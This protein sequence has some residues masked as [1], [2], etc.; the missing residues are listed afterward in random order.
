MR[1]ESYLADAVVRKV[2]ANEYSR[3]AALL[4]SPGLAPLTAETAGKLQTLLQPRP[5]PALEH[6]ER[7]TET[8]E[9][10]FSRK[11][12]K[13]ALRSSPKGSGAAVGGGRFEHWRVVLASP[14]AL[15]ISTKCCF[16]W[17]QA[18][19]QRALQRCSRFP[20]SRR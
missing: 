7:A 12:T 10:S 13:Q 4:A 16:L 5:T 9:T 1:D 6:A 14:S 19:C 18:R 2:L 17:Q 8:P 15:G 20:S 3:A 11:V